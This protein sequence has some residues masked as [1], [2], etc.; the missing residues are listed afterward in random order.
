M[1]D[2]HPH[3]IGNLVGIVAA[4][5][6]GT[7]LEEYYRIV[8]RTVE[9]DRLATARYEIEHSLSLQSPARYTGGALSDLDFMSDIIMDRKMLRGLRWELVPWVTTGASFSNL[10][11][12][13]F[14]PGE[15]YDLWLSQVHDELV[16]YPSEEEL[17]HLVEL[18]WVLSPADLEHRGFVEWLLGLTFGEPSAPGSFA[19]LMRTFD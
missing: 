11:R 14:G 1:I 9:A 7:A 10:N 15:G 3:L 6:G 12:A 19:A 8:G 16:R 17:Y 2:E 18:G 5:L 13:V 4:Q